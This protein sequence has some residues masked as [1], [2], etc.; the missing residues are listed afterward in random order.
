[1]SKA[2]KLAL[3]KPKQKNLVLVQARV[4][5]SLREKAEKKLKK[6]NRTWVELLI[7]ALKAYVS[8]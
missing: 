3:D 6:E 1:M 4:P 8:E 2:L 5:E 7:A